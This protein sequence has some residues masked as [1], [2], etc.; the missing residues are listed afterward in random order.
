MAIGIVGTKYGK[1]QGVELDGKYEG[2]T[3]FKGVPYAAPPVGRL[4]WA[5][6]EEPEP[7]AGVRL[8]DAYAPACVQKL[9]YDNILGSVVSDDD[10]YYMGPPEMSE[11]CLYINICTGAQAAGEKRPVYIWYHGGGLTNGYSYEVE[12]E[13][14]EL[15]RKG[16][17]VVTVGQRLNLFGYMSLPQI[18]AEQGGKSGNYSL[19]DQV[20]ALDWVCENIA[21]FGGDPENIT[22]GGQSGGAHRALAIASTPAAKGRV[23]R[24]IAQ[25]WIL[26]FMRFHTMQEAEQIGVDYLER[27]GI[28]PN[29]SLEELRELDAGRLFSGN[30]ER[31]YLPG[32]MVCDGEFVP[33]PTRREC[34]EAFSA[35]VDF[36]GG[37]N[38]GEADLFTPP[39]EPLYF[40]AHHSNQSNLGIEGAQKID[41]RASFYRY[42]RELLGDLYEKYD[43]ERLV[44]VSDGEAWPVARRLATL[45]LCRRGKTGLSKTTIMHRLFGMYMAKRHKGCRY[46]TYFWTH[47]EP[48][49]PEDIG[50]YR[51]PDKLLAW[52][53]CELYYTFGSMRDGVPPSRPWREIDYRLADKVTTYWS[54]FMKTGDPN[55]GDLPYWPAAN[56][57]F[58]YLE[59]GSEPVGHRGADTGLDALMLEWACREY[60]IA[61]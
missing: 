42:F 8:C 34:I 37:S 5:P 52:H 26:W 15:A 25:S 2:I 16:V 17:V 30:V 9:K 44:E 35:G 19:M 46:Y 50:T 41:D 38:W 27:I 54:N 31:C 13:N 21:A 60:E 39:G 4:R 22:V 43:F 59:L 56:D 58:G 24:V 7:W 57:D 40:I 6:P 36:L 23:R 61:L 33:F 14:S 32:D 1:L 55:G 48:H 10:Y 47:L 28:D 12:F 29:A 20:R 49:R 11:D 53:S 3:L 18:S 45:G 51:D